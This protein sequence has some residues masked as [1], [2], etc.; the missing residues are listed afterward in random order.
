MR[1][2]IIALLLIVCVV[3]AFLF[4]SHRARPVAGG[5][6]IRARMN[7]DIAS[8]DPGTR[9]DANTDAVLLHVAEGLV[10]AREDGSVGP[11]LA[12]S[13]TVS[14]DG[15]TY[16]FMLRH[17]IRFHNGAPFTAADVKWSLE[18]YLAPETHWRCRTDFGPGG[19]ARVTAITT[20]DPHIIDVTLDRAAPLFLTMLT[21]LDCGGTGITHRDSVGPDGKWR[22]PIGT[23][24]F[25]W[26]EWRH[27]QYVD[28]LRYA[29]YR[30]LP[31]KPDGNGGGKQALVDRIRFS[32]IPDGSAASAALLR[33][34]V[35]IVDQLAPN[36]LGNIQGS[37]G[38]K[39]VSAVSSEFY[40]VLLQTNTPTLRD[41]RL[42]QALA[43]SIDVAGLTRVSTHGTAVANSSPVAVV[44]PY[45]GA[46]EKALVQRNLPLARALVKASGYRGEPI[47]LMTS[48]SPPEMYDNA[49]LVQAMAREAGINIEVVSLDWATQLARYSS[50]DYQAS[51]FGF[52]ARLDPSL[53][54]SLL[55][56]DRATDPRK[57][58]NSP[59]ARDLLA[60]SIATGDRQQRQAL[61][62][63]LDGLFR[64]EVPAIVLYNT[65]RVTALRGSVVGYRAW[66]A[67]SLRLWNVAPGNAR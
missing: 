47:Q 48:H 4:L 26:G 33:G 37:P 3:G 59:A 51:I 44:S 53:T 21:R 60:R 12:S 50:G 34:S 39:L 42:R 31:G 36:E 7:A 13:W 35:D 23:G 5:S 15:R 2:A 58:W 14:P 28:L 9:R 45:H 38:I 16:R 17:G 25:R 29:D 10:A 55:I 64:Q 56:G 43:L 1:K 18:R 24:P 62:D 54:F 41:P 8:S 67:Q 65:R 32:V 27:N 22:Y 52:S 11:M 19:I 30:S 49:I 66:P 57:V 6:V 46:T 63:R 20:P 61:F 40:Y